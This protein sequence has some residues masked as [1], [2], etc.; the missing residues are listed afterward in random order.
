VNWSSDNRYDR[1]WVAWNNYPYRTNNYYYVDNYYP[2]NSF[3]NPIY[4]N[5]GSGLSITIGSYSP[6]Y[7][8]YDPF[9]SYG[10]SYYPYYSGYSPVYYPSYYPVGYYDAGYGYYD[11]DYYDD[12]YEDVYYANDGYYDRG[13]WKD[14]LLRTVLSV[15][16]GG[17]GDYYDDSYYAVDPYYTY[18]GYS[19]VYAPGGYYTSEPSWIYSPV[20]Y[21]ATPYSDSP[22]RS[23]IYA[24]PY[25]REIARDALAAGYS[26]GFI[27]GQNAASYGYDD[28]SSPYGY[29]P[30]VYSGYSTSLAERQR[31]L[32]EGYEIGYRDAMEDRDSYGIYDGGGNLDLV[33]ALLGNV[34]AS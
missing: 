22:Y 21:D 14:A 32:C 1:D 4:S 10:S 30:T 15:V 17:S 19:P 33:S 6:Y 28:Y 20:T 13:D 5:Y 34:M 7:S 31:Y 18:S 29:A 16:L 11:D 8:G 23:M 26:Q 25:T 9:Y 24:D 2:Y 3:Y 27:D 12:Y